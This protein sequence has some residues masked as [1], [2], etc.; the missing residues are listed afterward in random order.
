MKRKTEGIIAL[1]CFAVL[2]LS[3]SMAV[4][5]DSTADAVER[6]E[7][8]TD[9]R[10]EITYASGDTAF[11]EQ[12]IRLWHVADLT[13]DKQYTLT[14]SFADYPVAVTGTSS[15]TE[16]DEMTVTLN[17]YILA[18]G[19]AADRSAMT[20]ENG[21]VAFEEL[22]AGMYLVGSVRTENAGKA[23]VFESFMV[24]VPGVA[25]NGEWLYHVAAKPKMS[26]N[27]P[28]KGEVNYKVTKIWKDNGKN[29]PDSIEVDINRDGVW[30]QTVTLSHENDWMYSWK[31]VD[32]GSVW[33][34]TEKRVPNGYKVGIQKNGDTFTIINASYTPDEKSPNTGDTPDMIP[35]FLLMGLS[36]TAMV[37]LCLIHRKTCREK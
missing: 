17:A 19:I 8:R 32:D 5:A 33:S 13:A 35:Y 15:Q 30:R 9:C 7:L 25:E 27:T 4:C 12:D 6:A 18:D 14:G 31:T 24:A 10:L 34:V 20:D 22:T 21:T 36:G 11:A 2:L 29:R 37:I 3:A 16:W 1:L 23:V 26:E 28:S